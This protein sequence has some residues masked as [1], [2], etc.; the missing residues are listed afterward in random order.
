MTPKLAEIFTNIR[1][2]A[3]GGSRL[4]RLPPPLAVRTVVEGLIWPFSLA[5]D[6]LLPS[7]PLTPTS[8]SRPSRRRTRAKLRAVRIAAAGR[9]SQLPG[10]ATERIFGAARLY[11]KD[12]NRR[13]AAGYAREGTL[14]PK[15]F[16]EWAP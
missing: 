6:A 16:W 4:G 14:V 5:F 15:G 13:A 12:A 9:Q 3:K 7:V 8:R 11:P 1:Y 2:F 10:A